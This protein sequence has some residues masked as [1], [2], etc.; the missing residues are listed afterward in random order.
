MQSTLWKPMKMKRIK[1]AMCNNQLNINGISS[2]IMNYC[3]TID[4]DKFQISI[5]AGFPIDQGY[6]AECDRL[7]IQMIALPGKKDHMTGYFMKLFKSFR[8]KDFDI[9]HIHGSSSLIALELL[10]AK[11]KGVKI[12]I[13]HC[14][15]TA[16]S[17][18]RLH[19][20]LRPLCNQLYT[21]GFA[22]SQAAGEW[23]FGK[24]AYRVI[25]NGIDDQKFLYDSQNRESLRRAWGIRKGKIIGH[26]G[27][28]NRQKNQEFLLKV[29]AAL[30]AKTDELWLVLVGDGPDFA[31]IS[32]L[33]SSLPD[34]D[35]IILAG[36]ADRPEKFY[37]AFDVFAFPSKFEGFGMAMTEAQI[38]GLPCI[39]S[40]AVP[41]DVVIS[42]LVT[43]LPIE[44]EDV[45]LWEAAILDHF[46]HSSD[47]A[48]VN[49]S[50][51]KRFDIRQNAKDLESYYREMVSHDR[52]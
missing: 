22:C 37:S 42:D 48:T 12:R 28:M 38:N 5:L 47:R 34:A 44:E 27:R 9:V 30:C 13:A 26:I 40:T 23:L 24:R 50:G 19:R 35:H 39:A 18:E 10:I 7:G 15:N 4:S 21:K 29:F 17:H 49:Y 45:S 14:H 51:I 52:D 3:R 33:V 11:I 2:V 16:C 8:K 46:K 25:P 20:M 1:I 32:K 6:Q 36:E 31:H 41:N 43:F